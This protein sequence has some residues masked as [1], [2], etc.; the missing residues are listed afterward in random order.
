MFLNNMK[1]DWCKFLK[2]HKIQ[3][4]ER[5]EKMETVFGDDEDEDG[6]DDED[7]PSLSKVKKVLCSHSSLDLL[8][9]SNSSSSVDSQICPASSHNIGHHLSMVA[10]ISQKHQETGRK[11]HRGGSQR[12][13]RR[14]KNKQRKGPPLEDELGVEDSA[15]EEEDI[16]KD[17]LEKSREAGEDLNKNSSVEGC[18]PLPAYLLPPS[19]CL[20]PGWGPLL[21]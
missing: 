2:P 13:E 6:D 10:D 4:P 18:P 7:D 1:V 19:P 20:S 3:K 8:S 11:E 21:P 15:E 5:Q 16:E 17:V 14:Q 9:S 12:M